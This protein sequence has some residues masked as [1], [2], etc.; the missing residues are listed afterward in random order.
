[1]FDA[2]KQIIQLGHGAPVA[3]RVFSDLNSS[4]LLCLLMGRPAGS[5]VKPDLGW[6][7]NLSLQCLIVLRNVACGVNQSLSVLNLSWEISSMWTLR[8]P[9]RSQ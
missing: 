3:L 9:A 4:L 5:P 8:T 6:V 7:Y 2:K 1:M